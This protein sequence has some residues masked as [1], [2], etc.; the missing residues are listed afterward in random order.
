MNRDRLVHAI[1]TRK[2]YWN[3]TLSDQWKLLRQRERDFLRCSDNQRVK[4]ALR[5]EYI[6]ARDNFDK[7]LHQAERAY[8]KAKADEIETISTSNPNEFWDKINKL[9]PRSDKTIPCEIIDDNGNVVRDE[10]A[11]LG[12]WKRDFESLYNGTDNSEFNSEHYNRA[13]IHK[14]LNS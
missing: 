13:K 2:P 10:D 9:G 5:Q 11:V 1:K 6:H 7:S 12:K 4:T 8:R 14:I 3:D